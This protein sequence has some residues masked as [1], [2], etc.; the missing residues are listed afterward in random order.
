MNNSEVLKLK[1]KSNQKR[2]KDDIAAY[3][4]S[5][6]YVLLFLTFI[7]I[8]IVLAVFL[9]FTSYDMVGVPKLIGLNN[10]IYLLTSDNEFMRIIL[11]NTIKFA[12]IV[13]PGSYILSFIMAWILAQFPHRLRTVLAIIIYS[14]SLTAGVTMTVIWRVFF[15][16]DAS[17]YLNQILMRLGLIIEPIAFLQSPDY[18]FTIMIIVTLWGSMGI[19]FLAMLAGILNVNRE[20]YEAAYIDGMSNRYQEIMYITIPS[21]KPQMLFGAVMAIVNTFSAGVIGVQLSGSNPTPNYA[22]SLIVNHIEDYAFLRYEMGYAAALSLVLL[23]MIN[24][25]SKLSW[26]LFGVKE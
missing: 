23:L 17:G 9:S 5:L 24:L 2:K 6:P 20:L 15:A 22:G 4:F 13:G 3:W 18:L 21:M 12:V 19:G 16:G 14:P 25:F 10:F 11:P 26:K 1:A 7:V 8:P